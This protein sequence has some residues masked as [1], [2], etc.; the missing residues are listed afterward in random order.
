MLDVILS[1][2]VSD[3]GPDGEVVD[4]TKTSADDFVGVVT[5]VASVKRVAV[6]AKIDDV[7]LTNKLQ[8]QICKRKNNRRV[9]NK[10]NG[11]T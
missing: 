1:K 2:M 8:K 6:G 10:N 3:V 9:G 11:G 4:D 7:W 5:D